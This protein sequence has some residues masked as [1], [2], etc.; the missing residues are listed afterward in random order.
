MSLNRVTHVSI[1]YLN[2]SHITCTICF[3]I[4]LKYRPT[5]YLSTRLLYA[6]L[7][8]FVSARPPG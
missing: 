2:T 6:A 1:L 7:L 4:K 3:Y 5:S 8:Y